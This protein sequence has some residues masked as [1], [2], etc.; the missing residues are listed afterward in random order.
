MR[1]R[2]AHTTVFN[3]TRNTSN[4]NL[5]PDLDSQPQTDSMSDAVRFNPVPRVE[6]PIHSKTWKQCWNHHPVN[7]GGFILTWPR[8]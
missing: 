2:R 3:T 5:K 8:R 6:Q 7:F 4:E 1:N